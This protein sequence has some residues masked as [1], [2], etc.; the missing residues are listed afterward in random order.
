MAKNT[1]Q[2]HPKIISNS[3]LFVIILAITPII[4]IYIPNAI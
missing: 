1:D 3:A 2:N 4:K